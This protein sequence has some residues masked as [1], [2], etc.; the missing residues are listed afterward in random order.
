MLSGCNSYRISGEQLF[1]FTPAARG[2]ELRHQYRD[3]A[4]GA[5][6]N[7]SRKV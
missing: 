3:V 5:G 7:R 2:Y 1:H 6:D 4:S